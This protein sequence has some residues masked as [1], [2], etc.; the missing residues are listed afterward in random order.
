MQQKYQNIKLKEMMQRAHFDDKAWI[1]I[2][3][4]ASKVCK[5]NPTTHLKQTPI[6]EWCVVTCGS[7]NEHQK[8]IC[9]KDIGICAQ[10]LLAI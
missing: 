7:K 9:L 4:M 5:P 8:S 1:W 3:K 10:N 2:P 6:F